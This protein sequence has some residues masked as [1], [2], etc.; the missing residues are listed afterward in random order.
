MRGTHLQLLQLRVA[1]AHL[2]KAI[3]KQ[4]LAVQLGACAHGH[5]QLAKLHESLR[6]SEMNDIATGRY[7]NW[8]VRT[9]FLY[10]ETRQIEKKIAYTRL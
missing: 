1:N 3:G 2:A 10:T 9:T 6:W 8:A 4:L 7:I 5:R